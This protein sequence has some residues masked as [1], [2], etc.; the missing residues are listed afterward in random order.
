MTK[1][2]YGVL[3][4]SRDADQDDIKRAF[5]KAAREC[6][7]DVSDGER[8]V[9]EE[10]FKKV[11]EAYDVLSDPEKRQ[12]YDRF[13]TA[14]PRAAGG[15]GGFGPDIGDVFGGGLGDIFSAFFG[16]VAGTTKDPQVSGR[17][18]TAQVVVAL[19]EAA[20]GV[21]K[22]VRYAR[23]GLCDECG[24]SGSRT[25]T[26]AVTC[27]ECGGT[28][29][30]RVM[31]RTMLGTMESVSHCAR[32]VGMGRVIEDPCRTCGGLGRAQRV[33]AVEVE[34]PGGIRDGMSIRMPGAGEA[35]IRGAPP[36][37]LLVCVR[38]EADEH[39]HREGDDLHASLTVNV[40]EAALGA[41]VIIEG[42][43]APES[44]KVP[45]G[46]QHGQ[47]VVLKGRGMPRLDARRRGDLIVHLDVETP[48]KIDRKQRRLLEDLRGSFG[49]EPAK[50]LRK[51]REWLGR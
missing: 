19:R 44:L 36:G 49:V 33:E 26:G 30:V 39:L 32:C 27:P 5:R 29:R 38:V 17:D 46:S 6:H 40:A 13:G 47:T 23:D 48:R 20:A 28:G 4:V 24:G 41:D 22:T 9:N 1:D 10:R 31:R 51:V 12:M 25:G 14:D 18:M 42:L 35:G 37:D 50:P 2:Y 15:F 45:P 3:G 34:V 11:Y 8:E 7:P 21:R 43:E 16:D